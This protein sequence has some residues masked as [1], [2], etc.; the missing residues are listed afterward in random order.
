MSRHTVGKIQLT[1]REPEATA[2][3]ARIIASQLQPG[4]IIELTGSMGAGKT[5]FT[6]LLAASLGAAEHV[7]S[8]TYTIAHV[9]ELSASASLAHIDAWRQLQPL[10]ANEWADL[11]PALEATYTC[12]EWPEMIRPWIDDRP[13][14]SIELVHAGGD[15]RLARVSTPQ[16]RD[17]SM[18]RNAVLLSC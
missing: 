17:I 2:Q 11:A 8:P 16:G 15:R 9:Y 5:T 12:V 10:S 7:R 18:L 6:G 14:W 13:R 1:L 3:L 4:D